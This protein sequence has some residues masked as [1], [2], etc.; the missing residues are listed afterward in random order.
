MGI[1]VW[2]VMVKNSVPVNY[3][4]ENPR[5]LNLTDPGSEVKEMAMKNRY[6]A[7]LVYVIVI[8]FL[9]ISSMTAEN[10]ILVREMVDPS[11]IN[12]SGSYPCHCSWD[13]DR[14]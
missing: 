4:R 11:T 3:L 14:T 7:I 12:V 9:L 10:Q 1:L 8:L 13:G 6:A 5:I 2:G